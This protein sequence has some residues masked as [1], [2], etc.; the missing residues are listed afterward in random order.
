GH[1]GLAVAHSYVESRNLRSSPRKRGPRSRVVSRRLWIPSISAFTRVFDALCAG[2]SGR[3][4]S[5]RLAGVSRYAKLR[6][7]PSFRRAHAQPL[8]LALRTRL[9]AP[10]PDLHAVE[11]KIND[12]RGVERQEL[13]QREAADHRVAERLAQLRPRAVTEGE[14][15]PR[16]HRGRRR[17]QDRAEAQQAGFADRG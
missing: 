9:A 6:L 15:K 2:M 5:G 16:E 13:A 12:R 10:E 1:A 3:G 14:R 7:S 8:R 17:H 4:A 11:I